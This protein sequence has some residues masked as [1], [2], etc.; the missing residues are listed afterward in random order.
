M[1]NCLYCGEVLDAG[2]EHLC[3]QLRKLRVPDEPKGSNNNKPNISV[4]DAQVDK[5]VGILFTG[6]Q[7]QNL[8]EMIGTLFKMTITTA[9]EKDY[10]YTREEFPREDVKCRCGK[11]NCWVVKY[12]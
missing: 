9:C 8:E 11:P 6:V 4:G 7:G 5:W 12:E 10:S 2:D 1:A 3:A